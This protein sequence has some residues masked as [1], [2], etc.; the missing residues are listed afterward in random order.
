MQV[1]RHFLLLGPPEYDLES[2]NFLNGTRVKAIIYQWVP[3]WTKGV[4]A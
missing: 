3:R 2:C 4:R 1:R